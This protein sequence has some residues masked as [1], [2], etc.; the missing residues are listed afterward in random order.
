MHS[1]FY[2]IVEMAD[3]DIALRHGDDDAEPIVRIRFSAQIAET[4]AGAKY[5]V[6]RAMIES[7]IDMAIDMELAIDGNDADDERTPEDATL[8]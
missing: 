1:K 4:L 8:H 7:G 6:A 3:G 5:D 2:E